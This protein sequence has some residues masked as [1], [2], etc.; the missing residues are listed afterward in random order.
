MCLHTTKLKTN[1]D[2]ITSSQQRYEVKTNKVTRLIIFVKSSVLSA[3]P[4]H[5][6]NLYDIFMFQVK[7]SSC[8]NMS[9]TKV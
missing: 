8:L 5:S 2:M 3:Q 6:R 1:F 4:L 7:R 9:P